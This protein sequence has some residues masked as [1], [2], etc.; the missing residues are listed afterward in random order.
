MD[1]LASNSA[2]SIGAKTQVD[3]MLVL[4]LLVDVLYLGDVVL[5]FHTGIVLDQ[6][7][8]TYMGTFETK[9]HPLQDRRSNCKFCGILGMC[10]LCD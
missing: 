2:T 4:D 5:N 1:P 8:P 9:K 3:S 7:P 6:V 10:N